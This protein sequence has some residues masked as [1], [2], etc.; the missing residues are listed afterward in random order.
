MVLKLYQ[1]NYI[2]SV[3]YTVI[4]IAISSPHNLFRSLCQVNLFWQLLPG[5][6]LFAVVGVVAVHSPGIAFSLF[7]TEPQPYQGVPLH[8]MT[9]SVRH[10]ASN[11]V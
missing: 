3:C 6:C 1:M 4:L 11:S 9:D 10:K 8:K 5:V 7:H 2:V